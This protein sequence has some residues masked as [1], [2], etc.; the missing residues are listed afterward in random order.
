MTP[1]EALAWLDRFADA[2]R[3]GLIRLREV[4]LERT[5]ALLAALD[6]PER[7]FP[8]VLVAG[9]KGKG[10]TALLLAEALQACGLRIGL[11]T[12]PHLH[13][14]R[15]RIRV[16][17]RL[18]SPEALVAGVERLRE[19]VEGMDRTWGPP[20]WFELWT[21][22][23]FLHFAEEGVD[24]AVLEVGLGGRLDA[25]NAA[26]RRL[27]SVVTLLG[28]D[29]QAVLGR[30]PAKIAWEKGG[31]LRSGVPAVTA[32]QPPRA[33]GAL[34]AVAWERGVPLWRA[35]RRRLTPLAGPARLPRPYLLDPDAV[36]LGLPGAYQRLNARLALGALTLLGER[37]PHPLPP[38]GVARG[39]ARARWPGRFEQGEVEGVPVVLDGAHTPEAARALAA[40]L[41]EAYPERSWVVVLGTSRGKNVAGMVRALADR[42]RLWIATR[43]PHP[44][45]RRAVELLPHLPPGT[46]AVDDLARALEAGLK[47]ARRLE[48]GLCVTGSLFAVAA[49]REALGWAEEE[50]S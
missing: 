40:A 37:L 21:A 46:E 41:A 30:S 12:S 27:L 3:Q 35:D 29:H 11:Y 33:L 17:G 4:P 38:E 8:A 42:A 36:P 5:R 34:E 14:P 24:L 18:L 31:I 2:E 43:A 39:F 6:H 47:R 49:A 28:R 32:P 16:D 50:P 26:P 7:A 19:G 48:A 20:S 25:T 9:T 10:S 22:L 45:A 23:A 13:T 44:R 1:E 15:E